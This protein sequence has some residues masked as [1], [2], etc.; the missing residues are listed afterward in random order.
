[1]P[2]P[3]CACLFP[4]S[5]KTISP[6]RRPTRQRLDP[7]P[8]RRLNGDGHVEPAEFK[9]D[10]LVAGTRGE[11]GGIEFGEGDRVEDVDLGRDA[12]H[13]VDLAG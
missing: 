1:M 11:M 5:N 9:D 7:A 8:G 6:I 12:V 3:E 10:D 13:D 4:G 2:P